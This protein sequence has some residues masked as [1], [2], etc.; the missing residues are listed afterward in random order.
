MNYL[1]DIAMFTVMAAIVFIG[2]LLGFVLEEGPVTEEA[3]KVLWDVHRHQ[4]GEIHLVLSLVFVA[5]LVLHIILHWSWIRGSTRRILRATP[6]LAA[7]LLLPA[8]VVLLAWSAVA[9]N[10]PAYAGYGLRAGRG[11]GERQVAD[12]SARRSVRKV[13]VTGRMSLADIERQ[14]GIP[15][16]EL[17]EHLGL[18][19]GVSKTRNLGRLRRQHGFSMTRVR[20]GIGTLSGGR[21]LAVDSEDS[22]GPEARPHPGHEPK[23]GKGHGLRRQSITGQMTL[24]ALQRQTGVPAG[25]VLRRLKLPATTP[26]DTRL[27]WL[28]KRYGFSMQD[29][30]EA[31]AALAQLDGGTDQS[32]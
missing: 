15:A 9:K 26:L 30:R 2:L 31:V 19:A 32:R 7:V 1:V 25:A 17:A 18:P 24:H 29:V 5:L 8:L 27:G 28:R 16:S 20:D 23:T 3:S 21:I 13:E 14:T 11:S 10:D 12:Q 6:A 4:W 22:S